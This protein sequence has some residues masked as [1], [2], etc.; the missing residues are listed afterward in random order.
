MNEITSYEII[1]YAKRLKDLIN[2]TIISKIRFPIFFT[3]I[4]LKLVT[5]PQ[6]NHNTGYMQSFINLA[7]LRFNK[8][9]V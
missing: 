4:L 7:K 1:K 5:F 8:T 2:I 6:V 3:H 9:V